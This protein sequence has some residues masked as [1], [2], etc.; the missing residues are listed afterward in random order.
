MSTAGMVLKQLLDNC[1]VQ[2]GMLND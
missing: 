1:L 2:C